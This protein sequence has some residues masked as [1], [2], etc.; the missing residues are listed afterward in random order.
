MRTHRHHIHLICDP[1]DSSLYDLKDKL[2]VFFEQR[3]FLTQDLHTVGA[4]SSGYSWRC[5]NNCNFVFLLIGKSYGALTNT[6]VSQ[7]HISYLNAKT[8]GKPL[9][10][11]ILSAEQT[12]DRSRQ[13]NDFIA[14]VTAQVG[15]L[16]HI[17]Q[18]TD[19]AVLL[20]DIYHT[21]ANGA[22]SPIGFPQVSAKS[23][24]PIAKPTN[25]TTDNIPKP[26]DSFR[27]IAPKFLEREPKA[28]IPK[29]A[30]EHTLTPL[31][32]NAHPNLKDQ[33]L[34]KCTAHAFKGGTLIEVG[35]IA[36]T[37]WQAILIALIKTGMSFS[38]QGL[39]RILNDIVAPQAMPVVRLSHP[40]VHAISRCQATKAD[41]MWVQEQ[42]LSA[43][44]ISR[45]PNTINAKEAWRPTETAKTLLANHN[46]TI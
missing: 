40:D 43:D 19:T 34:L 21:L 11:L 39:W 16:H 12:A 25:N 9:V 46:Q 30:Y 31:T 10:G 15:Q 45:S 7:L 3:A 6:G 38:I 17:N 14:V 4:E 20:T 41:V 13:M 32:N 35:Y 18:T 42:L 5:I 23:V 2:A 8:K 37:T 36:A 24:I 29:I 27:P 28:S 33:V 44:W 22:T 1:N 26:T